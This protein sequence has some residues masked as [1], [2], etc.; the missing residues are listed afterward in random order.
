MLFSALLVVWL[1]WLLFGCL[2]WSLGFYLVDTCLLCVVYL[3]VVYFVLFDAGNLV[4][5]LMFCFAVEDC[6]WVLLVSFLIC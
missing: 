5:V 3:K 6:F 4:V 1:L 2:R